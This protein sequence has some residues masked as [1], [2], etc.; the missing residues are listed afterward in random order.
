MTFTFT[1]TYIY[2]G[3]SGITRAVQLA[4]AQLILEPVS[5]YSGHSKNGHPGALREYSA[6]TQTN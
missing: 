2:I 6:D 4:S 5:H 3:H 1:F